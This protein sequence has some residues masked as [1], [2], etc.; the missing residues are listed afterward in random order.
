MNLSSC[1]ID[2]AAC[3][4]GVEKGCKG[5]HEQQGLTVEKAAS[6][7]AP[8]IKECFLNIECELLWEREHFEGSRDVVVAL[9]TTHI[10]MDSDR[11]S[12]PREPGHDQPSRH[13]PPTWR[14]SS[15]R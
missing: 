4:I 13:P 10:C 5:C 15:K 1:G 14:R 11:W 12:V 3:K 6:V 7:N 9:K 2:C 8:N